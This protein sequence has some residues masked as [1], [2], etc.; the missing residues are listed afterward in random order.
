MIRRPGCREARRNA[1]GV[2]AGLLGPVPGRAV[3]LALAAPTEEETRS[4]IRKEVADLRPGL[5]P[6]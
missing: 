6:G 3:A 1:T 4:A 5:V 2:R